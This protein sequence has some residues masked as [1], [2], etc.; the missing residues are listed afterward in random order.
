MLSFYP[1][2]YLTM[3][4]IIKNYFLTTISIFTLTQLI[5]AFVIPGGF[6]SLLYSSLI[7]WILLFFVKP[8]INIIALPINIITLNTFSWIIH[9]LIFYIWTI[10]VPA[11]SIHSWVFTGL[12]IGP[13]TF[14]SINL[15]RWEVIILASVLS[16]MLIRFLGWVI[17]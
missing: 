11:I 1:I 14:S 15:S 9:A 7:L 5:P 17:K 3:R 8:V 16:L 13:V 2:L 10:L 12:K 6:Y 4:S